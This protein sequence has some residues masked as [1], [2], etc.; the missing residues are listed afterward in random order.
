MELFAFFGAFAAVAAGIAAICHIL[1]RK[2]RRFSSQAFGTPDI[3]NALSDLE[4]EVE[5]T[6]R[7]LNACD[8]LL[9]PQILRDFP[10]YDPVMAKTYLREYLNK[11]FSHREGF[12]IH[13]IAIARYLPSGAQKTIVYQAAVSWLDQGKRSQK[14]FDLHYTFLLGQSKTSVAANCPNCGGVLGYGERE[15]PYCGS[16]VANAMR[17]TWEFTECM[18]S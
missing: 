9:M 3:L 6:P 10:D 13:N 17:N 5:D 4:L 15:C 16:R 1:R 11:T 7:S 14:R 12:A 8:S 18:E 2:L